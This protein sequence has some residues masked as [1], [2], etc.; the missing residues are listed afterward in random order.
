MTFEEFA[1]ERLPGVLRF[2][3]VLTG[4]RALAEDLAQEVLIRAHSS[5]GKTASL[6]AG[7]AA[8]GEVGRGRWSLQHGRC[9]RAFP[10]AGWAVTL[11]GI[12]LGLLTPGS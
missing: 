4:D 1:A 9:V 10:W 7:L 8:A 3:A 6:T 5:W 11:C 12:L 2:A